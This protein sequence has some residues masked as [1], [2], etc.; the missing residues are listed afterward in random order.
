MMKRMLG[1]AGVCATAGVPSGTDAGISIDAHNKAAHDRLSQPSGLLG[2][3]GDGLSANVE[4]NMDLL[5]LL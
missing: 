5:S 1:F 4:S 3:A 2:G